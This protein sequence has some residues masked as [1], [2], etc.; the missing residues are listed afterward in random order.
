MKNVLC[1]IISNHCVFR[2]RTEHACL[3]LIREGVSSE[4]LQPEVRHQLNE[5]MKTQTKTTKTIWFTE[6]IL[7]EERNHFSKGI[8]EEKDPRRDLQ[9]ISIKCNKLNEWLDPPPIQPLRAKHWSMSHRYSRKQCP[10]LQGSD[11]LVWDD[12]KNVFTQLKAKPKSKV[13]RL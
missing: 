7:R 1:V 10:S 13:P 4:V 5:T 8:L 11:L 6:Q 2:M 3:H 12:S 9:S